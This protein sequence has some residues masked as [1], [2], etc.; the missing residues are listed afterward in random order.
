MNFFTLKQNCKKCELY[1]KLF[2]LILVFLTF[3]LHKAESY[4][5]MIILSE[6]VGVVLIGK[7]VC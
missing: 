2:L 6:E 3:A 4:Y 1:V 7:V 5:F